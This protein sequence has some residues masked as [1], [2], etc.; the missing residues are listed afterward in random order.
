[1]TTSS[2]SQLQSQLSSVWPDWKIT[3]TLGKGT[4][5]YVYQL[6]RNDLGKNYT[7]AMKVLQMISDESDENLEEFVRSVSHEIDMMM[8][9][10]GYPNIVT[11]EDYTVIRGE[12]TRTILIRMEQLESVEKIKNSR[13]G[14]SRTQTLQLGLDIC[15]ALVSCEEKN[16]IHRD[17]KLSNIFY[18]EKGGYKLGDFGISRTMDSIH[19]K[20]SMSSAGTIQYMAPEVYHG[21]KYDSSADL[22]SLGIALYILLNRNL[23]PLCN[24]YNTPAGNLSISMVHEANMRRLR[25]EPLP[26]PVDADEYL[27]SI[28]LTAC[29][30]DPAKRFPSASRFRDALQA[31]IDHK[32]VSR[33]VPPPVSQPISQPVS[34]PAAAAAPVKKQGSLHPQSY[35]GT[36]I[37]GPGPVQRP[38]GGGTPRPDPAPRN[39]GPYDR[40]KGPASGKAVFAYGLLVALIAALVLF[41]VLLIG[42]NKEKN[43]DK[44]ITV[45]VTYTVRYLDASDKTMVSES[46]VKEGGL[47]ATVTVQAKDVEGFKPVTEEE[48][49]KL[50]EDEAANI[51]TFYYQKDSGNSP[52]EEDPLPESVPESESESQQVTVTYTVVCFDTNGNQLLSSSGTGTAGST[53]S[54]APP[55]ITGYVLESGPDSLTLSEDE[56]NTLIYYY[57][58]EVS[59][60]AADIPTSNTITYNGHTYYAYETSAIDSY[61]EAQAYAESRGGYLAVISDDEENTVLYDYVFYGR[62]LPSAYFG[63]SDE[64][65]EDYWEWIDGTPYSYD[66]WAKGQPDN[67]H[68]AEHYALFYYKDPAYTWNDGDF[69]KDSTRGTVIFLIEWDVE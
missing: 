30:P 19:E 67:Q 62:D 35:E 22:Y 13:G 57:E 68:G 10:K 40:K 27:A 65:S 69:G 7:C 16:I 48:S 24:A 46:T 56:E 4:F 64:N 51:V 3:G 53:V 15:N 63:L 50:T 59:E 33:P 66:N 37:S 55:E 11:I 60:P 39:D 31:Y 21:Y 58:P 54:P 6:V 43:E 23:P 2:Y 14:L 28:I 26:P 42:K 29:S 61:Q 8:Q 1:M 25:G 41:L 32:P 12:G 52:Q 20:M 34:G 38:A 36:T 45:I 9:L 47:G 5:G 44:D 18:S 49:I 17:I